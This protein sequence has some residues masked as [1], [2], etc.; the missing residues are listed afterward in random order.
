MS[1]NPYLVEVQRNLPRLLALFDRDITN[2]SHGMGDRYYW[3]W[4]LI[5]FGN[6]TFQ[7]A[8]HGMAQ[9]WKAGLWPY[10][11]SKEDFI[12]RI[13]SLFDGA[14]RLTR[15]DGSLEEA[16][17]NEGSYCVT[18]L[19]AFDLLCTIDLLSVDIDESQIN[20]WQATIAPMIHYLKMAD[21]THALISNHLATAVAALLRWD[22]MVEDIGAEKKA[23]NLL[24]RILAHQ[25]Q[26]G[27]YMEYEGADPGYQSLCT[28]YLADVHLLRQDLGLVE[29]L[30]RSIKF[31]WYF[32]HPDGS[33]GGIYGSR[34]TRF[35]FPAGIEALANEI[36]EAA[37]LATFMKESIARN[38]VV[39]LSA[40]D[41]PNLI[42]MFNAYARSASL[43]KTSSQSLITNHNLP[44]L[45]DKPLRLNFP[46]AGIFLDRG[47]SHFTIINTHK[48]GVV[49]HFLQGHPALINAGIVLSNP[50][51]CL[52][53]T[54][55]FNPS[56]VVNLKDE[57]IEITTPIFAMPKQIPGPLQFLILRS[58]C[59]T[60]FRFFGFREMIKR[61]LV[62]L[63]I[64]RRQC[65]PMTN[66]RK[67]ILGASL[68][69]EDK[70]NMPI[71]YQR[72]ANPG[73]FVAIH[74]ASQGY[75]QIQDEVGKS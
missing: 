2:I 46:Q 33:F 1:N 51:G 7:G 47:Q 29:S 43:Q 22:K 42:P 6:G 44:C 68:Q 57:Q 25:S 19:V 23:L 56:N 20:Q 30:R 74:M 27:W 69:I 50:K 65:W 38:R 71:G 21:E 15:D 26:E 35:Y 60:A 28:Y 5:D 10:S 17:P 18:A 34:C 61:F 9:L 53:S 24:D 11:T 32:A 54:Q 72:V 73:S 14:K 48:G 49:Y 12:S 52:G 16:F 31:L 8:A 36:P 3:A 55:S 67:I 64:T 4:G 70:V 59:L 37:A 39:T 13:R 75:W 41:A 62:K 66:R 63:L 45:N 58:L 40:I